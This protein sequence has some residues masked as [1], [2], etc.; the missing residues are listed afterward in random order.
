MSLRVDPGPQRATPATSGCPSSDSASR[1]G[2]SPARSRRVIRL[3]YAIREALTGYGF[4]APAVILFAL[5]GIYPVAYGALLSLARWNGLAPHWTWV[6]I[7]N[8]RDL[9]LNTSSDPSL[10]ANVF[11]AMRN[12]LVT[13][14]VLPAGTVAISLPIA[15][16]LNYTRRLQGLL[17]TVFFLPYVT[18]GIAVYYAWRFMYDP[19]GVINSVLRVV[20]LNALAQPDGFLG[21]PNTSLWAVLVVTVWVNVPLGILLYLTGLQSLD[22]EA[23]EAAKIDGAGQW[24]Q[25]VSIV[26]PLLRPITALLVIVELREALQGFQTFLL[27]TNGGPLHRST[28]LGLESYQLAFGPTVTNLGLS[29]ALGWLLLVVGL[30][31]ALINLRVLRD[32]S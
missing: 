22:I 20:G 8:F 16:F 30:V 25:L 17:R 24:R 23:L 9:F 26:W 28:V 5:V 27:L 10:T 19:N 11:Q 7:A 18:N 12:T 32:R 14:V 1:R 6:G 29:A 15:Y 4:V 3:R 31:L 2:P 13:L 21:N